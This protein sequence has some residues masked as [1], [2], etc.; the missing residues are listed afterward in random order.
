MRCLTLAIAALGAERLFGGPS[1]RQVLVTGRGGRRAGA[2]AAAVAGRA[3]L[4]RAAGPRV[5]ATRLGTGSGSVMRV[6]VT[7]EYRSPLLFVA[8][9]LALGL[10]REE[11]VKFSFLLGVPI[12]FGG[13]LLKGKHLLEHG[14]G[15]TGALA[16]ALGTAFA[17]ISGYLCVAFLM[18]FVRTRN[19]TPFMVYRLLL[20]VLVL[21]LAL[22]HGK[23][24]PVT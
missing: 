22:E 3:P 16:F 23:T 8:G 15:S 19:F 18:R 11:A 17:A 5:G 20:G 1:P 2:A 13:C 21:Y 4:L 14:F 7:E 12:I 24:V 6:P 10:K 9:S